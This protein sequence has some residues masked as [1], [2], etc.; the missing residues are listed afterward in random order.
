MPDGVTRRG[1]SN[2]VRQYSERG[3]TVAK[4]VTPRV[5]AEVA[6]HFNCHT[7]NNPG[8][9][10]EDHGGAGT[11]GSHW[12]KRTLR[13]E[14]M[15]GTSTSNP[16]YS[17]ISLALFE[18]SGWYLPNYNYAE[19]LE[20]GYQQGCSFAEGYCS[21]WD[22]SFFCNSRGGQGCT[23]DFMSKG[24]CNLVEYT[25]DLPSRVQYFTNPR[26]G[27][28]D[29]HADFCPFIRPYSNG[30]CRVSA[31]APS[32][33]DAY[34]ESYVSMSRCFES[35]LL[36][37]RYSGTASHRGRCY[38]HRCR[39][40]SQGKP[41]LQVKI[42]SNWWICPKAGGT[43]N[44]P[45]FSGS[46]TCPSAAAHCMDGVDPDRRMHS[47]PGE[48]SGR[49]TCVEGKCNCQVGYIGDD[50]SQAQCL[51]DCNGIGIC[52]SVSGL[53][54]CPKPWHGAD[55]SIR[56]CPNECSGN[57]QCDEQTGKCQCNTGYT[58]SDC[59][60]ST[61]SVL[62][63]Q[64]TR[65][66]CPNGCSGRGRCVAGEC[67]CMAPW[68]GTDCS[69]RPCPGDCSGFGVCDKSTGFC[70]CDLGRGGC[71]CSEDASATL[72]HDVQVTQAIKK[73]E[74]HFYRMFS[75]AVEAS[76]NVTAVPATIDSDVDIFISQNDIYPT[77]DR[78]LWVSDQAAT[79]APG[80]ESLT[81]SSEDPNVQPGLFYVG[82]YGATAGT[83]TIRAQ[84]SCI[85]GDTLSFSCGSEVPCMAGCNGRGTCD[86]ATG[87]CLC[88]SDAWEGDECE[89]ARE[90][91][92]N[93]RV[94]Y[95]G[96]GTGAALVAVL[97][98]LAFVVVKRR[99]GQARAANE[100]IHV[101]M[102]QQ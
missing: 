12:E 80:T 40:D 25:S 41:Q 86:P 11:A 50:C 29:Q 84:L 93:K 4:I 23:H 35:S 60:T 92:S 83:Y 36:S 32:Q 55:C 62:P 27:G 30:D 69:E 76:L 64:I 51:N 98:V 6:R 58:G 17:A 2:V 97:G 59:G 61:L 79:G 21:Q 49:G 14:F 81:L 19:R 20:W 95:I 96:L 77:R 87:A 3:R 48:C 94:L 100:P 70:K 39:T 54:Q 57:G 38:E 18:D 68:N 15:T 91:A 45:N 89:T 101:P 88:H 66:A 13:N 74:Y 34:G 24:Y 31:N 67:Q 102:Q 9:E 99:Q 78:H 73:G 65:R 75:Q 90:L 8:M 53:C 56:S 72:E 71:D 1:K 7:M 63:D 16:K 10:L 85:V 46:I 28:S 44:I 52:D 43:V 22:D 42:G 5:R 82:V 26:L 33:P 47:C 37:D